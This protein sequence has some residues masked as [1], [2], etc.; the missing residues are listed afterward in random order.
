MITSTINYTK[1]EKLKK[2]DRENPKTYGK[3]KAIQTKH[4]KKHAHKHSEK[5]KKNMYIYI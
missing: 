5:G 4:T 3:S 2:T 1:K